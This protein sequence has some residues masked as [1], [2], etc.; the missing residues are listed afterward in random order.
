MITGDACAILD[1]VVFSR[2]AAIGLRL[3]TVTRRARS[4]L[5]SA[6][7]TTVSSKNEGETKSTPLKDRIVELEASAR[8]HARSSG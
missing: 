6:K 5:S 2:R 1:N 8:S 7:R 4:G 3:A